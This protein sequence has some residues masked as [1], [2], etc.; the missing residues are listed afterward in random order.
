MIP[1]IIHHVWVG[2]KPIPDQE[3]KFI[4]SWK[5]LHPE[6]D[7]ILWKDNNLDKLEI[8]DTC[9]AVMKN[10]GEKYACQADIVR[11]I[12]VNKF[13]GI[14]TDTDIICYKNISN[15]LEE[16][17]KFIALRPHDGNWIT[18]AFF[19]STPNHPILNSVISNM[20]DEKY[21]IDNPYGPAYLTRHLRSYLNHKGGEVHD[22]IREDAKV[23]N[24]KFWSINDKEA[25]CRHYFRA[26][27]RK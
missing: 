9:K 2:P 8:N 4:E 22:F 25:Y 19:A 17:L 1:K 16:K 12:A 7:F 26:S 3:K 11:Y 21:R 27:W 5:G 6:Y 13:G 10:A 20:K 24:S 15:L 14:Y 18:N 23:L